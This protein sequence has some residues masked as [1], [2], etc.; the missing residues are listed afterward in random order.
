MV[1]FDNFNENFAIFNKCLTFYRIFR[2]NLGKSYK[3]L[4]ICIRMGFEGGASPKKPIRLS[5]S[6]W[7]LWLESHRIRKIFKTFDIIIENENLTYW[8]RFIGFK[9]RTVKF[10]EKDSI[11]HGVISF[12]L[13]F[14]NRILVIF[15]LFLS[16]FTLSSLFFGEISWTDFRRALKFWVNFQPFSFKIENFESLYKF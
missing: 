9:S 7:V 5:D 6:R 13:L 10:F 2:E 4:E 12:R 8:I 3:N 15:T 16:S 11:G 14:F 1:I